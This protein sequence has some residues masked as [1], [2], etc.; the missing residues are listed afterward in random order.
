M[1][2][3]CARV[4]VI[5]VLLSCPGAQARAEGNY[6]EMKKEI[7]MLKE[8]IQQLE[9]QLGSE[10]RERREEEEPFEESPVRDR[11]ETLEEEVDRLGYG[12]RVGAAVL[13]ALEGVSVDGGATFIT[14]GTAGN[15]RDAFSDGDQAEVN[16]SADLSVTVPVGRYGFGFARALVGQGNGV[17]RVLPPLF[18]G[19][20]AD[21][22]VDED[23]INLVELWYEAAFP[24][25]SVSDRRFRLTFGKLD[26][27]GFFD[28]NNVANDET[29][30]FLA[31][32]FVN[33]LAIEFGGDENGY[34]LGT[35]LAWRFT[36]LYNKALTV[37]GQLGLFETGGDFTD[38]FDGPF[39]IGEIDVA[40][41][42]YGLMGNYRFYAWT[43]QAD[44]Q[45]FD[46]LENRGAKNW[47]GGL[48]LDQQISGDLTLFGRYGWQDPDVSTFDHVVS[49]GGQLVGNLW[50][51]GGDILG[52]AVGYTHASECYGRVSQELDG[53]TVS[54]GETYLEAYY[55]YFIE[56]GLRV[57]PD[58]QYVLR[59]S[60]I[61]KANDVFL[62]A[63]RLQLNF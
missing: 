48:S 15:D 45:D 9:R 46:D 18:S 62:Y 54:G 58:I 37:E 24:Y 60:G 16:F 12:Q 32:T 29:Q 38:T 13:N 27:M 5:A 44:H 50:R 52:L 2:K 51:R 20:N 4:V 3:K 19:P 31:D 8:R 17:V 63:L 53:F 57:T 7:E 36:S 14:Q 40:R 34:G 55:S 25:P 10:Q 28:Q 59:P 43:N 11:L 35:R 56:N 21:L 47:G 23:N 49:A 61:S 41:R 22:E 42:Y 39:V 33:N 1:G 6:D 26:P 30:Q